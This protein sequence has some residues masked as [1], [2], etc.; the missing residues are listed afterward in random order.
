MQGHRSRNS[1]TSS[2]ADPT[3]LGL[4]TEVRLK[5]YTFSGCLSLQQ[6]VICKATLSGDERDVRGLPPMLCLGCAVP[7]AN[8][9]WD[10]TKY[11]QLGVPVR[12]VSNWGGMLLKAHL[13]QPA[14]TRVC[15][16]IRQEALSTWYGTHH[17][18]FTS[19]PNKPPGRP[20]D[21]KFPG[22]VAG[23]TPAMQRGACKD[24]IRW[25]DAIGPENASFISSLTLVYTGLATER[26]IECSLLP[27]LLKRGVRQDAFDWRVM[28]E[29]LG[30][31]STVEWPLYNDR[32][33]TIFPEE[34]TQ[35]LASR[36]RQC[37]GESQVA[38]LGM[39][40]GY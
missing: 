38:S 37:A 8:V 19:F 16:K 31:Q 1:L 32:I 4:P 29:P 25:I 2:T 30:W 23:S 21:E 18:F 40:W 35:E 9:Y 15:S 39:N 27:Q 34:T 33:F 36:E 14:I 11:I 5:I 28:R 13:T 6:C 7:H 10:N 24:V 26:D 12:P 22:M 3:F 17:W 20:I